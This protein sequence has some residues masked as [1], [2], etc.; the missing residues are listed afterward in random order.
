MGGTFWD[1]LDRGDYKNAINCVPANNFAFIFSQYYDGTSVDKSFEVL[2]I[3]S[4]YLDRDYSS[5]DIADFGNSIFENSTSYCKVDHSECM[6]FD[7]LYDVWL[8]EIFL[9]AIA[10]VK[11]K[12]D[13]EYISAVLLDQDKTIEDY[14]D[15]K[16][17]KEK[18]N[19]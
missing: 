15:I 18:G 16:L 12:E 13:E 8:V 14:K 5:C 3:V 11:S 9:L 4:Y 2:G 1:Y 7:E 17:N 10:K 19:Q 6:I